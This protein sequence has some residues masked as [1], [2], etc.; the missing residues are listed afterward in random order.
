MSAYLSVYSYL[1]LIAMILNDNFIFSTIHN[2][3][4][5]SYASEKEFR[6][7]MRE[8]VLQTIYRNLER[9]S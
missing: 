3:T 7:L 2:S 1:T 9:S 8:Q 5:C 6:I 4:P